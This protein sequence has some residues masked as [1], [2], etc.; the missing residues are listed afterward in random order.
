MKETV[1]LTGASGF[2]GSHIAERLLKEGY[3]LKILLRE[4]SSRKWLKDIIDRDDV[5][6][7]NTNLLISAELIEVLRD[8][9]YVIHSAG[10]TTAKSQEE[11]DN[12]NA[13][14]TKSLA[15]AALDLSKPLKKIILIS[16][17]SAAGPSHNS[18]PATEFSGSN[19]IS[20]YGLSKLRGEKNLL[21]Y[22]NKLPITILRP[23]SVY[24]PRDTSFLK[25]FKMA[26][27]KFFLQVSSNKKMVNYIHVDD[28]VNAIMLTIKNDR[29]L[30]KTY[31]VNDGNSY[32]WEETRHTLEKVF[33]HKIKSIPVPSSIAKI[34]AKCSNISS[35]FTGKLSILNTDKIKEM[36]AFNWNA[37]S[38]RIQ[39]ELEYKA[40]Y[41][42]ESGFKQTLDWYKKENLVK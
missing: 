36:L 1:F 31:F 41:D 27:K 11:F 14:P 17:Q 4:S 7:V 37:S 9:D 3:K 18:N 5:K 23:S 42:L 10:L 16:S 2:V 26:Q 24:G 8:V 21:R 29:S 19:P 15:E 35:I 13:L 20:M 32:T 30:G 33:N 6:I 12:V 25:L 22:A 38:E 39:K 40:K 34:I 28:F